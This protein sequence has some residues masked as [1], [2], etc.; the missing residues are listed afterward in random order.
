MN[1]E[2]VYFRNFAK[3]KSIDYIQH[4]LNSTENGEERRKQNPKRCF[5]EAIQ[6][7]M[8]KYEILSVS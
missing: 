3:N 8:M 7:Q 2:Q 5:N 1:R 4:L 6:K